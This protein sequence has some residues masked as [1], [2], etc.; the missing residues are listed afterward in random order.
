M[1][2]SEKAIKSLDSQIEIL[3]DLLSKFNNN[4][5]SNENNKENNKIKRYNYV[6]K[7]LNM[8]KLSPRCFTE[9]LF[10]SNDRGYFQNVTVEQIV[11]VANKSCYLE[12]FDLVEENGAIYIVGKNGFMTSQCFAC[13]V[14]S[15]SQY[16]G[17]YRHVN[18]L[19]RTGSVYYGSGYS[20]SEKSL[21]LLKKLFI[22]FK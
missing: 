19:T 21:P 11:K 10:K 2:K 4:E 9:L 1:D 22:L 17:F 16:K 13:H 20:V 5:D 6:M 8:W 18:F 15:G 3:A 7:Y 14:S 12:S